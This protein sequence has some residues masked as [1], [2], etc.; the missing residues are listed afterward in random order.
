MAE[1]RIDI[2]VTERG[3][4]VV[5]RNLGDVGKQADA[6]TK[7][8]NLLG[9]ALTAIG[10]T[11]LLRQ[12]IKY[13][14]T[15]TQ[16]QS[17]L[18]LVTSGTEDLIRTQEK[19]FDLAQRNRTGFEQTVELYQRLFRSTRT[20][21]A[22]QQTLLR[23]IESVNKAII[24]S[25]VSAQAANAAL[26]QLGQ[27][28]ASGALRGD[29]LRSV[30]EQTPRLAQAIAEGLGVTI[31]QLRKLGTEGKLTAK[32]VIEALISQGAALDK[33]FG[34]VVPTIEQSFT[35]L[36]NVITKFVGES[37]VLKRVMKG[38][39]NTIE[40]VIENAEVLTKVFLSLSAALAVLLAPVIL[41]KL[42]ALGGLIAAIGG[43]VLVVSAAIV[44]IGTALALFGD[45][46]EAAFTK[47]KSFIS[48][49]SDL[50]SEFGSLVKNALIVAIFPLN[51]LI[52][53]FANLAGA[54][55]KLLTG[56]FSVE[57]FAENFKRSF[58]TLGEVTEAA[59]NRASQN[60]KNI[61]EIYNDITA[62][63]EEDFPFLEMLGDDPNLQREAL[64]GAQELTDK[65]LKLRQKLKEE[66][67]K[68]V[69]SQT[70]FELRQ[71]TRRAQAYIDGGAEIS[72][73]V[74]F[75]VLARKKILDKAREEELERIKEEEEEKLKIRE[76]LIV[77]LNSLTKTR[78]EIEKIELDKILE[79][80]RKYGKEIIGIEEAIAERKKVLSGE[81]MATIKEDFK[82]MVE[83]VNNNGKIVSGVL[84][85]AFS[86]AEEAFVQFVKTGKLEFNDLVN[87]ILADL[88][89]LAFR[90]AVLS[91]I[92]A[93]AGAAGGGG[94]TQTAAGAGAVGISG[95][96]VSGTGFS[97][98][99]NSDISGMST[100]AGI[101]GERQEKGIQVN[102]TNNVSSAQPRVD[103]S[104]VN[105]GVLNILI[106]EV[107]DNINN[108]GSIN[109]AVVSSV[110][111][112]IDEN[113]EIR[114]S[115]RENA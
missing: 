57:E 56:D 68:L 98:A 82:S 44:G 81:V 77:K 50:F 96:S 97:T 105:K 16:L 91:I 8:V 46:I 63:G 22:S 67:E 107:V 30:L 1:E 84:K 71:V 60:L 29:E 12:L 9:A 42:A 41:A 25:G 70:E 69:L 36:N 54:I 31:G 92:G 49:G 27:G 111:R 15:F 85:T 34:Q 55:K 7:R 87:S 20:L 48:R 108:E 19:L 5:K 6:S 72:E 39:A 23:V 62:F 52:V 94:G 76:K 10:G 4:R 112:N 78:A 79:E 106:D 35:R 38:I 74:R 51:V 75:E 11:L 90:K 47:L 24:I 32:S 113:G 53:G 103:Q 89:R 99:I 88:T 33:E 58:T 18:R 110:S 2:V 13:S 86:E 61:K 40:I 17:R 37:E 83:D 115:I 65:Q 3:T 14:D 102:I 21:G 43:P 80:Y 114:D 26:V 45:E 73:A 109:T 101:S 59:A 95:S 28:L 100:S 66:I 104:E 93:V 64:S